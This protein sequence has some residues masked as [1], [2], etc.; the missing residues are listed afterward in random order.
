[1]MKNKLIS[2]LNT[3]NSFEDPLSN[4][5]NTVIN[6]SF[7]HNGDHF[8]QFS[9]NPLCFFSRNAEFVWHMIYEVNDKPWEIKF[10]DSQQFQENTILWENLF[11]QIFCWSPFFCFLM[12]Q[13]TAYFAMPISWLAQLEKIVFIHS[14]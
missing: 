6:S 9:M 11:Y 5:W 10:E 3:N 7:I 12:K 2:N 13:I 14:S 1:M 4:I 8:H